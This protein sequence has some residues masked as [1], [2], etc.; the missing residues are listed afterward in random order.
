MR[1]WNSLCA[2]SKR[3]RA[4]MYVQMYTLSSSGVLPTTYCL[5]RQCIHRRRILTHTESVCITKNNNKSIVAVT[6]SQPYNYTMWDVTDWTVLQPFFFYFLAENQFRIHLLAAKQTISLCAARLYWQNKAK[7][8][9]KRKKNAH[10]CVTR[11]VATNF[12][13]YF[14]FFHSF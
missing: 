1:K 14:P 12:I 3:R 5:V 13:Y 4:H 8:K 9:R 11:Q 7:T 10:Q 6:S 2:Y